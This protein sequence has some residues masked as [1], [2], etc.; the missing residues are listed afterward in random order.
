MIPAIA[1]VVILVAVLLY[2]R[3]KR[4]DVVISQAQIDSTLSQ[5]FPASKEYLL[6]FTITYS[7]PNVTLLEN[8]DRV[9]VGLDAVLNIR[10]DGEVKNLG[11]GAT[12]TSSIKYDPDRQEFFLDDAVFDRLDVQGIPEQWLDKAT[13]VAGL[14]ANE[15]LESKPIYRIQAKDAT[16]AAARLLLKGFDVRE[17]S[18]HVTLGI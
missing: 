12:V 2:F 7:N 18:I 10:L 4:Y 9:Q 11:G 13:E 5:R 3:G 15:F 6:F 14:A 16:T 17:Q 1:L 8:E